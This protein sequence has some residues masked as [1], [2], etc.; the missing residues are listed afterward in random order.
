[1]RER[2]AEL[3]AKGIRV[4]RKRGARLMAAA[5]VAGVSGRKFVTTTT[6]KGSGRQAPD[7]IAKSY[8]WNSVATIAMSQVGLSM[9]EQQCNRPHQRHGYYRQHQHTFPQGAV[10]PMVMVIVLRCHRTSPRRD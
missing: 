8:D 6:S 3:A 5:G 4:G 9:E 7:L 10:H 2:Y 1:V